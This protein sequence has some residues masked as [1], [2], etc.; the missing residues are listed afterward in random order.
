MALQKAQNIRP[1]PEV[2]LPQQ[3]MQRRDESGLSRSN[4]NGNNAPSIDLS[5]ILASP[6]PIMLK[7]PE[8]SQN[9]WMPRSRLIDVKN[10]PKSFYPG[11]SI[12]KFD[13]NENLF[14]DF[15]CES[16]KYFPGLYA[17]P[18]L[19]CKVF[20]LCAKTDSGYVRKTFR[21]PQETVFDQEVLRCNWN[22]YVDCSGAENK[23]H[24]NKYLSQSFQ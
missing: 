10:A 9:N 11:D 1:T 5:A 3:N 21:C 7:F 24:F 13:E 23:Y 8:H 6:S 16:Q 20:H 19:S 2:V 14:T 22:L 4:S 12:L 18:N 17:D 15:Q